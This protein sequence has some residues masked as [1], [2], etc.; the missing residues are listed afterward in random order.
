MPSR[1]GGA[2]HESI[3]VP[4]VLSLWPPTGSASLTTLSLTSSLIKWRHFIGLVKGSE[5]KWAAEYIASM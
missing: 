4:S 2:N 3:G 1:R 5:R